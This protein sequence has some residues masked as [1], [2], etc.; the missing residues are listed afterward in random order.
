MNGAAGFRKICWIEPV[1]WFAGCVQLW[2]S[3]AIT[4]TVLTCC[5]RALALPMVVRSA[6]APTARDHVRCDMRCSGSRVGERPH[7]HCVVDLRGRAS[8]AD[9]RR[10]LLHLPLTS[11]HGCETRAP[12]F[13]VSV[14]GFVEIRELR[15]IEQV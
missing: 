3:I 11:G 13:H 7:R 10:R 5:A 6:N 15:W 14:L 2:F 12:L 9:D 1:N 4:N 8:T